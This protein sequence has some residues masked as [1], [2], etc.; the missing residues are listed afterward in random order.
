MEYLAEKRR[1]DDCQS[2]QAEA[3]GGVGEKPRPDGG[4]REKH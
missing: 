4:T 3:R 2:N 1:F